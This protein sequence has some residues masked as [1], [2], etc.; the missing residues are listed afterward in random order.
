MT[1]WADIVICFSLETTVI[2]QSQAPKN[3]RRLFMDDSLSK[4]SGGVAI[5]VAEV[6]L[7]AV[8]SNLPKVIEL[9]WVVFDTKKLSIIADRTVFV[10]SQDNAVTNETQRVTGV[11]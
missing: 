6:D 8:K 4:L 2:P 3:Y 1:S 10:N 11:S 7:D 5:E 9:D